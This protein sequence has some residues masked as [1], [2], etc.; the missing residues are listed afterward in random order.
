[1]LRI[2]DHECSTPDSTFLSIPRLL[3]GSGNILEKKEKEYKILIIDS[4]AIK[5][6][7]LNKIGYHN[8]EFTAVVIAST[9]P[10]RISASKSQFEWGK[11]NSL[12]PGSNWQSIGIS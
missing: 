9:R 12:G 4:D 5:I 2:N 1:M 8:H 11:G 10:E 7:S 6:L 3:Q